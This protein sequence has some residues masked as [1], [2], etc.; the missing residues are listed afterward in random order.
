MNYYARLQHGSTYIDLTAAPYA[1]DSKFVPPGMQTDVQ[2]ST[3]TANNTRGGR[4]I[5]RTP[6]DTEMSL[7]LKVYGTTTAQTHGAVERLSAFVN[8]ALADKSNKLYF[9]YHPNDDVPHTPKWGQRHAYYE[10]KS[11]YPPAIDRF[12]NTADN[13]AKTFFINCVFAIGPHILGRA[14][15]AGSATGGIVEQVLGAADQRSRGLAIPAA[16]TNKMTNPVYGHSTY[17]NGWSIGASASKEQITDPEFVLFGKSSLLYTR[18]ASAAWTLYQSINA[19]NTNTHTLTV[20]AKK[21]DGSAV[22]SS[23][24]TLWYGTAQTTTY[25]AVGNGWY[26]L[27]ASFSGIAAATNVG[28]VGN[29][30]GVSLVADGW[31]L[32][33][34]SIATPVAYGDLPGCAW[35]GTAHASTSTRTAAEWTVPFA[36]FL[37][38]EFTMRFVWRPDYSS[39]ALG[40]DI[41]FVDTTDGS[42]GVRF[43][44]QQS[45]NTWRFSDGTNTVASSTSSFTAASNYVFHLVAKRG[46]LKIYRSG[47]QIATGSTYT[48]PTAPANVWIGCSNVPGNHTGGRY[49]DLTTWGLGLSESEIA[50]DYADL[51]AHI[52]GDGYGQVRHPVPW[53]WTVDGDGI[54]D[55]CDDS[56]HKNWGIVGGVPGSVPA[57]TQMQI[58][59]TG[60]TSQLD[61]LQTAIPYRYFAKQNQLFF[62]D[63]SGGADAAACGGESYQFILST[64]APY[65]AV[66][67]E[68][69][70]TALFND[71][72]IHF[73][74]RAKHAS[75]SG[76][77]DANRYIYN[78]RGYVQDRAVALA[79]TT[80]YK[81][82]YLG[83]LL[84]NVPQSSGSIADPAINFT[85]AMGG[86]FYVDFMVAFAG[87]RLTITP[88]LNLWPGGGAAG[89]SPDTLYL[90]ATTKW[91]YFDT[92][93][94]APLTGGDQ[95]AVSPHA[96]NML[97]LYY[98]T[99]GSSHT[100]TPAI[101]ISRVEVTPR[102]S[103][104]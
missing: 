52:A 76:S 10:I 78:N 35:S 59:K 24:A 8:A 5:S 104:L 89:T 58:D 18:R 81:L 71:V 20:Y 56:T 16:T 27:S 99:D 63:Q 48:P 67:M 88:T 65:D 26:R 51:S 42:A 54:Y 73:Y 77:V 7:P 68:P 12:Y 60:L 36:D 87:N 98:N 45:S 79:V 62:G 97:S 6:R 25:T 31:H 84:L 103:L 74:V 50:A 9:V 13:R 64:V 100:L 70:Y 43:F 2:M 34:K 53:H 32:E 96:L 23:D 61:I 95:I 21:L 90:D 39:T 75:A 91:G 57:S 94:Y 41:I 44:Y 55:G 49:S 30:V 15:L 82:F 66:T 11:W 102:W 72:P 29:A 14:Q 37:A 33:E 40:G 101:T 4:E 22:T 85:S 3:G 80:S 47:V 19:G 46:S 83:D 69:V 17:D 1:L 92:G 38:T 86:Y 93:S 28:L